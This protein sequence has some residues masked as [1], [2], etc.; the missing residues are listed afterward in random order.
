MNDGLLELIITHIRAGETI[1][2]SAQ[3]LNQ[4]TPEEREILVTEVANELSQQTGASAE[5]IKK[6]Y[7]DFLGR[8]AHGLSDPACQN[9]GH[10]V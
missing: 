6:A 2:I 7:R 4:L 5:E 3:V 8:V 10:E 1:D 9:P